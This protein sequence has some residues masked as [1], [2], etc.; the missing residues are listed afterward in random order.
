MVRR[1]EA[2]MTT[3]MKA[4]TAAAR[5]TG[6]MGPSG[7]ADPSITDGCGNPRASAH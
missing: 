5:K 2:R 7:L 1:P 4:Y 3:M 6:V